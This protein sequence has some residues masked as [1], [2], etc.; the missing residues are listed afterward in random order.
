M[1][2]GTPLRAI[3]HGT[4]ACATIP[5]FDLT[6]CV[7]CRGAVRRCG[8]LVRWVEQALNQNAHE[9][10]VES[11]L[12]VEPF[13]RVAPPARDARLAL[14][15]ATL[16]R[17]HAFG[18]SAVKVYV[19]EPALALPSW[20]CELLERDIALRARSVFSV[21]G[22]AGGSATALAAWAVPT[23]PGGGDAAAAA[24]ATGAPWRGF[25]GNDLR[26]A[27]RTV[28]LGYAPGG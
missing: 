16:Q 10:F 4:K 24:T 20:A 5:R 19:W 28:V 6:V 2:L 22:R 26:G 23:A 9:V 27:N 18:S 12:L 7:W 17:A 3:R 8:N 14:L 25:A 1:P 13:A 21:R 15:N 11:E